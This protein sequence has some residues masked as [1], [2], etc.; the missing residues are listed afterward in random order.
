MK[1]RSIFPLALT[2]VFFAVTSPAATNT[3]TGLGDGEYW[4]SEFSSDNWSTGLPPG[5][6]DA[7]VFNSNIAQTGILSPV[8]IDSLTFTSDVTTSHRI[9]SGGGDLTIKNSIINN[10]S[11]TQ[12]F[13]IAVST[14]SGTIAWTGNLNFKNIVNLGTKTVALAG[15]VSFTNAVINISINS[16]SLS[17][18]GQFNVTSG[19]P[20]FT[21]TTTINLDKGT[22]T[23]F[24]AGNSFDFTTGNFNNATLGA[25]PTLNAGLEWDDTNFTSSGILTV[26]ASAIPEPSTFASLAGVFVL[27]VVAYRKRRPAA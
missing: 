27:G 15:N 26:V 14:G 16:L 18:F 5:S 20:L 19:T 4:D 21:G 23:A 9:I 25:L 7:V 24:A 11:A 10:S 22:F 2:S 8:S 3:W 1:P 6:S 17:G 12:A 13:D